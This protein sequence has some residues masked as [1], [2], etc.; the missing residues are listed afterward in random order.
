MEMSASLRYQRALEAG[1][2]ELCRVRARGSRIVGLC[3]VMGTCSVTGCCVG[4]G[5]GGRQ[6]LA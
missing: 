6:L 3:E 2:A 1:Q 5:V 4:L